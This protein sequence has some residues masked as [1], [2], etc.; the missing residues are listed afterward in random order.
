MT[1]TPPSTPQNS[2]E[3]PAD[4]AFNPSQR[5][6][7]AIDLIPPNASHTAAMDPDRA[8]AAITRPGLRDSHHDV[9]QFRGVGCRLGRKGGHEISWRRHAR[10]AAASSDCPESGIGPAVRTALRLS[11]VDRDLTDDLNKSG[12]IV[13]FPE[14]ARLLARLRIHTPEGEGRSCFLFLPPMFCS[15]LARHVAD[16]R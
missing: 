15:N 3:N 8:L 11:P 1:H 9:L 10:R 16:P 7:I 13:L 4:H 5:H 2:T 12:Q 14:V 6:Q